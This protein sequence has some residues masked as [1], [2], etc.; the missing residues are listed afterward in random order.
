MCKK[1][2][3]MSKNVTTPAELT[4]ALQS[5]A[6]AGKLSVLD[7]SATW[8]GPCKAIAPV[9]ERLAKE[10]A[11]TVTA[12]K[13]DVDEAAVLADALNVT[14]MPS[15]FVFKDNEIVKRFSGASVETL[16][17]AF[18]FTSPDPQY[19]LLSPASHP[20]HSFHEI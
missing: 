12:L 18:S 7:C 2:I 6:Q 4:A 13:M 15:F 11:S 16:R 10:F 17:Q 9:F 8:C 3:T 1:I 5:A 20:M 14:S 19:Q